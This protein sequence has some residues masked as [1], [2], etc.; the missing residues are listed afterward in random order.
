MQ[1]CTQCGK[2]TPDRY[3]M[4]S[5]QE[6]PE[7]ALLKLTRERYSAQREHEQ[8][9]LRLQQ[10]SAERVS[11]PA[12]PLAPGSGRAFVRVMI[13]VAVFM[14][15]WRVLPGAWPD[16]VHLVLSAALACVGA[17]FAVPILI[18]SCGLA[19]LAALYTGLTGDHGTPVEAPEQAAVVIE[20]EEA[21]PPPA[22]AEHLDSPDGATAES[23]DAEPAG[24]T[25]GAGCEI[26]GECIEQLLDNVAR[27]DN[28]GVDDA[29][30]RLA[31]MRPVP[32]GDHAAAIAE[33]T[34]GVKLYR[35]GAFEQSLNNFERAL[36]LD[37]SDARIATDF[38]MALGKVGRFQEAQL[39]LY[40]AL[41]LA[42]RQA[43]TWFALCDVFDQAGRS[44][45]ALKAGLATF[46]FSRNPVHTLGFLED[47][48]R[49]APRAS[50]RDIYVQARDI[51][52][53]RYM[54]SG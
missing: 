53:D 18:V 25:G 24:P 2:Q 7:C 29:V 1:V 11:V 41:S 15:T 17:A 3:E 34:A 20:E 43:S 49:T 26:L 35:Q 42:P 31:N 16:W 5:Y 45:L 14:L 12:V 46:Y 9:M 40:H 52:A 33:D 27:G 8:E 50:L 21:S 38:G 4:I 51:L 22:V 30:Q 13:G 28:R 47:A 10:R 48:A 23:K 37:P 54:E 6:C 32:A 36:R 19:V 44:D 39:L